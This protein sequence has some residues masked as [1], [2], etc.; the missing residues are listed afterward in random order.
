MGAMCCASLSFLAFALMTSIE[1]PDYFSNRLISSLRRADDLDPINTGTVGPAELRTRTSL[2]VA[3]I[4]RAQPLKPNDYQIVMVFED[5]AVL[6]TNDEL[7]R[8]KVGSV[9][10]G[11]GMVKEIVPSP[12]GGGMV[13]TEHATLKAV[14]P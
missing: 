3:E 5:E 6:A 2:P 1:D 8:V 4:A 10:P 14:A 9:L 7:M 12:A 11:L 13:S